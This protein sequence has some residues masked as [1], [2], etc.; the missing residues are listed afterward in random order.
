MR[1]RAR[2]R[3]ARP[4]RE[5]SHYAPGTPLAIVEAGGL[6]RAL[7]DAIATGARVAVLA[8]GDA[9]AGSEG[10]V[11][12]RMPEGPVAYARALYRA[13]R[14]LDAARAERILVEAVPADEAWAAVADRLA[15]AAGSGPG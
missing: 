4:G 5:H 6:E 15:R 8:R 11:W 13:L 9:P 2:T 1:I 7:G 3:P 12:R 10:L 14:A